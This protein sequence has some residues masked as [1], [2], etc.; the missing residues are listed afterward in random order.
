MNVETQGVIMLRIIVAAA[1]ALGLLTQ[2][3]MA[4]NPS[5]TP[6][7]DPG[8]GGTPDPNKGQGFTAQPIAPLRDGSNYWPGYLLMNATQ[9]GGQIKVCYIVTPSAS[10][11]D[12]KIVVPDKVQVFLLCSTTES[13]TGPPPP[14]NQ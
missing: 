2:I 1:M 11:G 6:K 12:S 4:D 10:I 3:S 9:A 5:A 8:P 13:V 7:A 14:P